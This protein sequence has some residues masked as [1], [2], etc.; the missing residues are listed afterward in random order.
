MPTCPRGLGETFEITHTTRETHI[1]LWFKV[2]PVFIRL[3][4]KS[5]F[6]GSKRTNTTLHMSHVHIKKLIS[7]FGPSGIKIF[8]RSI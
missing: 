4:I 8:N 3:H 7:P 2:P 5:S 1:R 6:R